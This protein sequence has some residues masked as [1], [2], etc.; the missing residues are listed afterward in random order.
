MELRDQIEGVVFCDYEEKS[1][2]FVC[3]PEPAFYRKVRF[4]VLY[5]SC[6]RLMAFTGQAMDQAGVQDP[7]RCLFVDDS[8]TNVESARHVGWIRSVHFRERDPKDVEA[9]CV[10]HT[11]RDQDKS[12]K[13]RIP[14]ISDLQQLREVWSDVF[15]EA[16]Q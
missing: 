1:E 5:T 16:E 6:I 14:V 2:D 9:Q 8:L 13:D 10:N 12:P 7:T 15:V 11:A 4:F 3:K